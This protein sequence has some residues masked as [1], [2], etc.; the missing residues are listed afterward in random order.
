M[1]TLLNPY[2]SQNQSHQYCCC[3]RYQCPFPC[4]AGYQTR[5]ACSVDFFH[6]VFGDIG[7]PFESTPVSLRITASVSPLGEKKCKELIK[8]DQGFILEGDGTEN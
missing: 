4:Q 3:S 5:T 6:V 7:S 1:Y 2:Q 8:V